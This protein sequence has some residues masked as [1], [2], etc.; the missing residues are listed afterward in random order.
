[1]G[2]SLEVAER[3]PYLDELKGANSEAAIIE[4]L[5]LKKDNT[6]ST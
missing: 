2:R 1:V 3:Y 6:T 4:N 5:K